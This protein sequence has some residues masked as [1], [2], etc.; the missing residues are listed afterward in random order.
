MTGISWSNDFDDGM[1]DSTG[2]A[3]MA[4]DSQCENFNFGFWDNLDLPFS[5][6]NVLNWH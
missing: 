3:G 6:A 5:F 4:S 1:V 2:L